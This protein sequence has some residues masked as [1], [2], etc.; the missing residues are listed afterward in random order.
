MSIAYSCVLIAA[1]LP[2]V[3]TVIAKANGPGYTNIAPRLYL[4]K[5]EGWRK[6]AH[7]TQLNSFE[8]FPFFAAAV[9]IA[10]QSFVHQTTVD[11]IAMLFIVARVLYGICYLINRSTLRSLVWFVGFVCCVSLF[12]LAAFV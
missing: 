9:I 2:Y 3:F 6:R 4:E 11:I 10:Q 12:I 5:L 8:A 7:W 1:L